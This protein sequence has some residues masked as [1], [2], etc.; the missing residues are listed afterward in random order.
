MGL[1]TLHGTTDVDEGAIM[2]MCGCEG[3]GG[4][5]GALPLNLLFLV[6]T[7]MTLLQ[8]SAWEMKKIPSA[9]HSC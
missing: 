3:L 2:H 1:H 6:I 8:S 9:H 4:Q 5:V 7:S